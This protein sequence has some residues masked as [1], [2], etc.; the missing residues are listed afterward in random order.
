M[1]FGSS[2]SAYS[3]VPRKNIHRMQ[4]YAVCQGSLFSPTLLAVFMKLMKD[5]EARFLSKK[6]LPPMNPAQAPPG[7]F[8]LSSRIVVCLTSVQMHFGNQIPQDGK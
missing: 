2:E 3:T 1:P 5:V 8:Q 4:V 7:E 6:K